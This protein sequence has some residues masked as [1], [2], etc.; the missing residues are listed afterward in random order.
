MH[1][2]PQNRDEVFHGPDHVMGAPTSPPQAALVP[3]PPGKLPTRSTGGRG[4][5]RLFR[6]GLRWQKI[7]VVALGLFATPFVAAQ[8][9][10]LV[11]ETLPRQ[12]NPEQA[13]LKE[14]K[15]RGLVRLAEQYCRRRLQ[16]DPDLPLEDRAAY[17]MTLSDI[18]VGRVNQTT[19]PDARE[20]LWREATS[21]LQQ[22][23]QKHPEGRYTPSVRYQLAAIYFARAQEAVLRW[24]AAPGTAAYRETGLRYLRKS[25]EAI[26]Q[27]EDDVHNVL[28]GLSRE[29]SPEVYPVL[30]AVRM[31]AGLLLARTGLEEALCYE[32]GSPERL[33][34]ARQA[35]E[36]LDQTLAAF[37]SG[38][39]RSSKARLAE[40]LVLKARA[41][42]LA[43]DYRVA[44]AALHELAELEKTSPKSIPVQYRDAR[45]VEEVRLHAARHEWEKAYRLARDAEQVVQSEQPELEL[46][47][48]EACLRLAIRRGVVVSERFLE[49]A[50]QVTEKIGQTYGPYWRQRAGVILASHLTN[51]AAIGDPQILLA[52]GRLLQARGQVAKALQYFERA[53][54]L[55]PPQSTTA[56][57][58]QLALCDALLATGELDRAAEQLEQLARR[59]GNSPEGAAALVRAVN[60][61][62]KLYSRDKSQ[63]WLEKYERAVRS[64]AVNHG[65]REEGRQAK[66]MLARLLEHRKQWT[67]AARLY[68]DLAG[69]GDPKF[70][71]RAVLAA[72]RAYRTALVTAWQQ[73]EVVDPLLS[74]AAGFLTSRARAARARGNLEDTRALVAALVDL[75]THSACGRYE[76]AVNALELLPKEAVFGPGPLDELRIGALVALLHTGR[77][78]EAEMVVRNT[79]VRNPE[80]IVPLL[81]RL[82][83]LAT[84]T[85]HTAVRR[86]IGQVLLALV[87]R[88]DSAQLTEAV[89]LRFE[90]ARG[91]ALALVGRHEEA[92][93]VFGAVAGKLQGDRASLISY[94]RVLSDLG[95]WQAARDAWRRVARLGKPGD[96]DF[97][98]VRYELARACLMSGD[99]EQCRKIIQLTEIL[100]PGLGGPAWKAKFTEL[101]AKAILQSRP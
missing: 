100:H 45:L 73:G 27:V 51:P 91:T 72:A 29:E 5:D 9:R 40:A 62:A 26:Q 54:R 33:S 96:E 65:H 7:V 41:A 49:E 11:R 70:A 14:L 95:Q 56:A 90:V 38:T 23:L 75:Y 101:K 55:A 83:R 52:A 28:R 22:F 3:K 10:T 30:E 99:A 93:R 60:C 67:E 46:L 79:A 39:T 21:M 44:E 2:L 18:L 42:I 82:S 19:A 98:E 57:Q 81:D 80:E 53:T 97:F 92:G 78:P 76:N 31:S 24:L 43:S 64:L 12:G 85:K 37:R 61:Y 94:A 13:F 89:R 8:D 59:L 15:S 36:W 68:R 58:A 86:A 66:W 71:D 84:S 25:R 50:I 77:I 32:T 1:C 47:L 4:A 16:N 34:A 17:V 48:L 74:E 20:A 69:S 87:D 88:I 6:V 35:L 63:R